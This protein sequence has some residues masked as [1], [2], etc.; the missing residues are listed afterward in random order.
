M[1][2][3]YWILMGALMVPFLVGF[4]YKQFYDAIDRPWTGVALTLVGVVINIPLTWALVG[5]HLPMVPAMGLVGAGWAAFIS[6]C[7]GTAF[8]DLLRDARAQSRARTLQLLHKAR[9]APG[10]LLA[11]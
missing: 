5:G 9:A 4:V 2:T 10:W 8:M 6:G 7:L 11:R 3:A 1:P